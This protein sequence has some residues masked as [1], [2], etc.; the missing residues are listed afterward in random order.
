MTDK[1]TMAYG[2]F[3]DLQ[4]SQEDIVKSLMNNKAEKTVEIAVKYKDEI[5]EFTFSDFLTRLGFFGEV[6]A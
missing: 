1:I 3:L 5:K 2:V 4:A 6:K